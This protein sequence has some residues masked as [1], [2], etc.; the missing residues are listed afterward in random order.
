MRH[1]ALL[2]AILVACGDEPAKPT[3]QEI[4][5]PTASTKLSAATGGTVGTDAKLKIPPGALKE[6]ADVRLEK[7]GAEW[8]ATVNGQDHYAFNR[9]IEIT[10][11]YEKTA[12]G[13]R[14]RVAVWENDAW[15]PLPS[16]MN[17]DA[18][19][20]TAELTHFSRF[21]TQEFDPGFKIVS[22]WRGHTTRVQNY[23]DADHGGSMRNTAY[24]ETH[25]L[26]WAFRVEQEEGSD[27][28]RCVAESATWSVHITAVTLYNDHHRVQKH[29]EIRRGR[30]YAER[31]LQK[32]AS[33]YYYRMP[34]S[35][36]DNVGFSIDN[37]VT[38]F[39][40]TEKDAWYDGNLHV[41]EHKKERRLDITQHHLEGPPHRI[42]HD[43][44]NGTELTEMWEEPKSKTIKGEVLHRIESIPV[45][46]IVHVSAWLAEGGLPDFYTQ[47]V[48]GKFELAVPDRPVTLE[49]RYENAE[50]Q[51]VE[52]LRN[53]KGT[54]TVRYA[55]G[56][57]DID[58]GEQPEDGDRYYL[59]TFIYK[60]PHINQNTLVGELKADVPRDKLIE[61]CPNRKK[62]VTE[63][64]DAE[65]PGNVTTIRF[66]GY[67]VCAPTCCVM[68][69]KA[70]GVDADALKLPQQIYDHYKANGGRF[71]FPFEWDPAAA[72]AY[73]AAKE[74]FEA[75]PPTVTYQQLF[76]AAAALDVG[77]FKK[78]WPY[79]AAD[80]HEDKQWLATLP[81]TGFRPWQGPDTITPALNALFP[82]IK[83]EYKWGDDI[84][85][86]A[87]APTVVKRLGSGALAMVSIDHLTRENNKPDKGGHY[88]AL[89]GCIV[90][91]SGKIV[92]LIFN[93]PYGDLTQHPADQG[94]Y[95]P[96][97]LTGGTN[98]TTDVDPTGH[99]GAYVP[100]YPPDIKTYDGRLYSKYWILIRRADGS[101]P[102]LLKG[103]SQ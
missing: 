89:V 64:L 4:N 25:S 16:R 42:Q 66:P 87:L 10:L 13:R 43:V 94:Y 54:V 71:I 55:Q 14:V 70:L 60:A 1:A 86:E 102:P 88:L 8:I 53:R 63:R 67:V 41:S 38:I 18:Q 29:P 45:G 22:R 103:D 9:P 27:A 81:S 12:A 6:D 17:P 62:E 52:R 35:G 98:T 101:R 49:L 100:Y 97:W 44:R 77:K 73:A 2:L 90:D 93:D 51:I 78:L 34:D 48:D 31:E 82:A 61:L 50:A 24:T 72:Q 39:T 36:K 5:P 47:A 75:R 85:T 74:G 96:A 99:K 69:I 65:A 95:D 30:S 84:F 26:K 20:V 21:T 76:D 57:K 32:I 40:Y 91:A 7:R 46:G 83:A 15:K 33:P 79:V 59:G 58:L 11:P 80:S 3:E 37:V 19:T 68:A 23:P 92:R 56:T 28:V